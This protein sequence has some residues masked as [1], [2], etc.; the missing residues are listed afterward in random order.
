[1][2]GKGTIVDCQLSG[3][4]TIV[5]CQ[6]G[7]Q[8]SGEGTIVNC[9]LSGEGTIVNCQLSGKGTIVNC[10]LSGDGKDHLQDSQPHVDWNRSPLVQVI[11]VTVLLL[12]FYPILTILLPKDILTHIEEEHASREK[13]VLG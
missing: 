1:M 7:A 9:K 6:E 4:G 13:N 12:Y 2:S 8:L 3:E 10:K 5:N 11:S